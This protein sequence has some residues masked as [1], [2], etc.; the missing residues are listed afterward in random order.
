MRNLFLLIS[1]LLVNW[2]CAVCLFDF[3]VCPIVRSI[4]M[5]NCIALLGRHFWPSRNGVLGGEERKK[6]LIVL[7]L[8]F[9]VGF[10]C[11]KLFVL[12]RSQPKQP[13]ANEIVVLA[14]ISWHVCPLNYHEGLAFVHN[15]P[16][17]V[18][19]FHC[20]S[21]SIPCLPL[22]FICSLHM[23][24]IISSQNGLIQCF[25]WP[26]YPWIEVPRSVMGFHNSF[27]NNECKFVIFLK[28]ILPLNFAL[29]FST[30]F[31][32]F[33]DACECILTFLNLF[34]F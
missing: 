19:H 16:L 9:I 7:F 15:L 24:Y 5:C 25:F 29:C 32:L 6:F 11:I 27:H 33:L 18:V 12:T 3:C 22:L 20:Q 30:L 2:N 10:P 23:I 14:W 1:L 13:C 31:D 28:S 8:S 26:M 4:C 17:P 21:S 34:F